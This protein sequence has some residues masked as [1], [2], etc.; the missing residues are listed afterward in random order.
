MSSKIEIAFEP[1]SQFVEVADIL[2]LKQLPARIKKTKKY[3]QIAASI[4]EVGIIEPPVVVRARGKR[5]KFLLLDGHLRMEVLKDD[6]AQGVNCLVATQDEAFTYNKRINRLATIQEHKMILK[7]IKRGVPEERLAKALDLNINS[8]R[9]KRT[10][11]DGICPE[12]AE[13]LKNRHCPIN[14]FRSL[15]KMKPMR[16]IE[17]AET[18]IAMSNFSVSYSRALLAATPQDQLVE[19]EKP[20]SFKGITAE[21]LAKMESEMTR[22]QQQVK[23][24]EDDYGTD[25]LTL[26]LARGY[27]ASL[28]GNKAVSRYLADHHAELLF[29]FGRIVE[30]VSI[31]QQEE[32]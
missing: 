12:V 3:L 31:G 2:P 16:Q 6:G 4:R 20:K 24:I 28:L 10:L 29:E 7:A 8:L 32:L 14:T 25:H 19:S 30:A 13:L 17:V 21:Q 1:E 18:M 23:L 22:L 27:L 9:T 5:G 15:K 11:L 26:I